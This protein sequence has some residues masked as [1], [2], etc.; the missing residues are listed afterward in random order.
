M[1]TLLLPRYP[2]PPRLQPQRLT[3]Y[4]MSTLQPKLFCGRVSRQSSI[5]P[6]VTPVPIR[7]AWIG[8]QPID[9]SMGTAQREWQESESRW[10]SHS[11]S[12]GG[13]SIATVVVALQTGCTSSTQGDEGP[14]V[15]RQCTWRPS[16]GLGPAAATIAS[17]VGHSSLVPYH[18]WPRPP[19]CLAKHKGQLIA[20]LQPSIQCRLWVSSN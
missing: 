4:L 9:Q 3:Y 1:Q 2:T 17:A 14:V 8:G 6:A 10:H 7:H 5:C 15:A 16:P 13:G 20:S 12:N 19:I 18:G 11:A